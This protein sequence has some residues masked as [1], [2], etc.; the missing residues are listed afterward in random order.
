MTT[1]RTFIIHGA[2]GSASA[3]I[4]LLA[5]NQ[6]TAQITPVAETDSQAVAL[7]Y[8]INPAKV[9]KTKYPKYAAG[10]NCK[11]C[12]LYQGKADDKMGGCPLFA[13]KQVAASAWCSAWIKK[14]G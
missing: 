4:G 5:A 1:R 7:S 14:A 3:A 12:Q 11:S 10:Q 13:G 2:V 9:D 8:K 6:A